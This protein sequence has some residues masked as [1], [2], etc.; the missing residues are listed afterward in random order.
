M[1]LVVAIGIIMRQNSTAK[2]DLFVFLES[3]LSK[4]VL[5]ETRATNIAGGT[6]SKVVVVDTRSKL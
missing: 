1:T 5:H 6:F 3:F 2:K 4:E